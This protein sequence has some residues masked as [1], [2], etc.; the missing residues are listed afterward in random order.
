MKKK[1]KEMTEVPSI[2]ELRARLKEDP[3]SKKTG[4]R[5]R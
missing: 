3:R 2:E 5:R 1:P 4:P